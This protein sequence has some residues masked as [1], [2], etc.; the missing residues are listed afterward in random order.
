MMSSLRLAAAVLSLLG[1][2]DDAHLPRS[3]ADDYVESGDGQDDPA[4]DPLPPPRPKKDDAQPRTQGEPL[5]EHPHESI[6]AVFRSHFSTQAWEEN[7]WKGYLTEPPVLVPLGLAIG[8][9]AV[10]HWDRPLERRI[11]G[12][13]GGRPWI[14][15]ATMA[16]LVGGS[17]L[18]GVFFPGEGRNGWDNFWEEAEVLAVN[19]AL[20]SSLK[21]LVGRRRPGGGNRSF[22]SGHTSSAFAAA[23][24][25]NDNSGGVIGVSSYGLAALT[26]Y[27][28]MEARRHYPSDVLAGAAIGILSAQVLDYLHWGNGQSSHGIAGG[29]RLEIEP[30]DRGVMAAISFDY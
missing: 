30:L 23:S 4:Q 7:V 24:L 8:A 1:D 10:S 2:P 21:M 22:P 3:L 28:R 29:L 25:I 6:P 18:L 12:S 26:G 17:V 27:S 19:A 16:T 9:G 14:G 20:T 5:L 11:G 15:D 13:L